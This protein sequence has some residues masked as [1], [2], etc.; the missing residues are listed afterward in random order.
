MILGFFAALASVVVLI[1]VA[2]LGA[3]AWSTFKKEPMPRTAVDAA[4]NLLKKRKDGSGYD[5]VQGVLGQKRDTN[6]FGQPNAENQWGSPKE[7]RRNPFVPGEHT[8]EGRKIYRRK[9][10][11]RR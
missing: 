10:G 9:D 1:A 3:I 8:A 6:V 7:V 2:I 11:E 4:G 5:P